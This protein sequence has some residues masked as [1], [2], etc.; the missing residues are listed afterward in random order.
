MTIGTG[1]LSTMSSDTPY[2][3]VIFYMII[4]GLG[5]GINMPIAN[6][7]IQNSVPQRQIGSATSTVK[8]FRNIGSTIGSAIYG[9]I[10]TTAMNTGFSKLDL[11][12]IPSNVQEQLKNPQIITNSESVKQI[13]EQIPAQYSS[14]LGTALEG[15]KKVLSN[16]IHEIFLFCMFVA[17]GGFVLTII[18]KDAP[19]R[20]KEIIKKEIVKNNEE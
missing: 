9:T 19:L 18:F 16:S 1:L 13:V 20:S 6:T 3:K 2:F 15:A 12:N 7:N 11:S 4:L 8:F 10:M 14:F 17:I 5:I